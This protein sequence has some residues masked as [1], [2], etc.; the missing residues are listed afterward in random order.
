[1]PRSASG[2][3]VFSLYIQNEL[4]E[5]IEKRALQEHRTLSNLISHI[6]IEYLEKNGS[7]CLPRGD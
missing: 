7:D 4:R 6:L 2:H 3:H 5:R 1:M